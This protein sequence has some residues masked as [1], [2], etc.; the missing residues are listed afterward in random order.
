MMRLGEGE[1]RSAGQGVGR[2]WKKALLDSSHE[3]LLVCVCVCV[4]GGC[5]H[6]PDEVPCLVLQRGWGACHIATYTL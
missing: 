5:G 2:P 6:V 4:A 3:R 1:G